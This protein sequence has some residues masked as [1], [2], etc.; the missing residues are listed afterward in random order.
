[1][2]ITVMH[3]HI[4][5]STPDHTTAGMTFDAF[6]APIT[7]V[8]IENNLIQGGTFVLRL[9][10][11]NC[12][13]SDVHVLNNALQLVGSAGYRIDSASGPEEISGSYDYITKANIDNQ[14]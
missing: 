5:L 13:T 9:D 14:L 1:M 10:K 12:S 3:N 4:Y 7:G 2:R 6:W 8:H 11:S